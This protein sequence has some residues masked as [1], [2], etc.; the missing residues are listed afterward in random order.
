MHVLV[1]WENVQ[2]KEADVR[3]LVEGATDLWLFHG[4]TQRNVAEHHAGFGVLATP[5][6][7]SRTGKNALDFHLSFYMGY[8][9]ARHPG[10]RFVVLSNDKGYAPMLEHAGQLA[11]HRGP[12]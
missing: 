2:P 4:P 6:R 10:A 7:I 3:A 11:R 5:V 8:V 1:D 9:A 12:T